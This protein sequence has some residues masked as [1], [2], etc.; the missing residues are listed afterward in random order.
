MNI[1]EIDMGPVARVTDPSTS[2]EAAKSLR[3]MHM[4]V[5]RKRILYLL[6]VAM[7][8]EELV[9]VFALRGFEGT[10]SGIRS[11]RSELE[12][13]GL[14]SCV[15]YTFTESRRRARVFQTKEEGE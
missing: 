13:G 11:R 9:R 15:G 4:T 6:K 10:P 8:D 12:K 14:V 2:W 3:E 7:H 5:M 1:W